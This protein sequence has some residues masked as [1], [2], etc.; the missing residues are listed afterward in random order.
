MRTR[1][2][3]NKNG[4]WSFYNSTEKRFIIENGTKEQCDELRKQIQ[5]KTRSENALL[6]GVR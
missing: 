3:D 6:R 1:I 2:I 4:T 5:I